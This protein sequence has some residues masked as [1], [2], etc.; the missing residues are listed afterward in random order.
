VRA[1]RAGRIAVVAVV[2]GEKVATGALLLRIE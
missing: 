2:A 1:P